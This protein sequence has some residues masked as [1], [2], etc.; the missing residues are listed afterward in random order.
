MAI[1]VSLGFCL[2]FYWSTVTSV[3]R[4]NAS[5]K[6]GNN[7]SLP[8]KFHRIQIEGGD[9]LLCKFTYMTIKK[10]LIAAAQI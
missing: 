5:E 1:G 3:E 8:I 6:E 7:E 10:P 4:A 9:R 2:Y